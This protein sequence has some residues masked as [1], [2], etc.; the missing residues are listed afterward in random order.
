MSFNREQLLL[1]AI[2]IVLAVMVMQAFQLSGIVK[3]V[4]DA[5]ARANSASLL[6]AS[7]GGSAA[8]QALAPSQASAPATKPL[9][10]GMVGG[11]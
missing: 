6:A 5:T 10:S 7:G 1:A 2:G 3:K 11:C 9:G 4:Q 8:P